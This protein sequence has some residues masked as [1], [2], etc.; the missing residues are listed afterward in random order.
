MA[1]LSHIIR[2]HKNTLVRFDDKPNVFHFC[3]TREK[4]WK[5][6]PWDGNVFDTSDVGEHNTDA[7]YISF[8]PDCPKCAAFLGVGVK[9]WSVCHMCGHNEPGA[10]VWGSSSV[11]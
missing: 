1:P 4:N 6:I 3:L 8:G 11:I 2:Q 5:R 9:A 7:S 10:C